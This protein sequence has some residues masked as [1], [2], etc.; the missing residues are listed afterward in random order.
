MLQSRLL[1]HSILINYLNLTFHECFFF[2]N[3]LLIYYYN[4]ITPPSPKKQ[5][6]IIS[7]HFIFC[8][9]V[10]RYTLLVPLFFLYELRK[11]QK[12]KQITMV[13]VTEDKN[14]VVNVHVHPTLC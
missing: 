12:S 7:C 9:D 1:K 13:E 14:A 10:Y 11:L 3:L 5:T 8:H 4:C 2:Y 6:S